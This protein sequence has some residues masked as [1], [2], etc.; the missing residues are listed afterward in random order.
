MAA[1]RGNSPKIFHKWK[2]IEPII[3]V[4]QTYDFGEIDSLQRQWLHIKRQVERS[5]PDAY[6]AFTDRLNRRWSIETGIIE[7]IYDLDRGVTE[8]LVREGITT[9]YIER[10]STNREPSELVQ[11]LN[12]H[13]E[14]VESVNYWIE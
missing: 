12:D 10:S 3:S 13:Q 6:K 8:T 5:A 2:P 7:G 14:S 9:D 11:I 4:S 1:I